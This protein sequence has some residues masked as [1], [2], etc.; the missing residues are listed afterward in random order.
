MR[1]VVLVSGHGVGVLIAVCILAVAA[2]IIGAGYRW[3]TS[4]QRSALAAYVAS[5]G[6]TLTGRDDSWVDRFHLPP[7]GIGEQRAATDVITGRRDGRDLVA[8]RYRYTVQDAPTADRR[9]ERTEVHTIVA[10]DVGGDGGPL[11]PL[12]VDEGGLIGAVE[13]GGPFNHVKLESEEF[14]RNFTI[15]CPDAKFAYDVLHPRLMQTLLEKY[16][17]LHWHFDGRWLVTVQ[18]AEAA[19]ILI[20]HALE[21][22]DCV[23][24]SLPS[25]VREDHGIPAPQ[26]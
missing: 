10:L 2:L 22:M 9:H 12:W 20:D 21:C 8:F 11:P 4:Q 25:F 15:S 16:R 14:N 5:Q 7:F 3:Y 19:P 26:T 24:D 23:L 6:W 17:N 1:I 18:L 13:H